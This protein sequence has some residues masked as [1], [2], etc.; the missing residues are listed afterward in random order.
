MIAVVTR[1]DTGTL[2]GK[3]QV[4]KYWEAALEKFPDLHF[5][6]HEVAESVGSVALYYTSVLDKEAIEVMF[7]NQEG[8]VYKVI[9][10]YA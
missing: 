8:K 5:E 10:H 9:A 7:F 4:R 2:K 3:E 6:L 1:A